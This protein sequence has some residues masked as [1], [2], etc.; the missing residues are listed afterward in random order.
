VDDLVPVDPNAFVLRFI[1]PMHYQFDAPQGCRIQSANLP[2]KDWKDMPKPDNYGP[3]LF[4]EASLPEPLD[5]C[6]QA[7]MQPLAKHGIVRVTVASLQ[8]I[9]LAVRFTPQDCQWPRLAGAHATLFGI[10]SK[11]LRDEAI[12]LFN[13]HEL[14]SPAQ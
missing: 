4:V 14:K 2:T 8:A 6:L 3:S 12:D 9:G 11:S 7:E 10:S 5:A 1:A 13:L